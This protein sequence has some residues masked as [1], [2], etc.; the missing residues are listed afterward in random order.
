MGCFAVH[1]GDCSGGI[2]KEHYVSRSVL[3]IAGNTVQVS[4]FPWQEP[5]EP[6]E[7]GIGALTSRILCSHHNSELSPL[8]ETASKFL[9]ALKTSFD[10]FR[11]S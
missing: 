2:S 10:L 1:L 9:R 3:A 6:L 11:F 8:D 4:G 7:I 5:D